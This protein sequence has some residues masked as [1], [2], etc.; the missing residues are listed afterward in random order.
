MWIVG[1]NSDHRTSFRAQISL[2][3]EKSG[4]D[5]GLRQGLAA[6]E[7][8][9]HTLHGFEGSTWTL[10]Q[11]S[12]PERLISEHVFGQLQVPSLARNFIAQVAKLTF[13]ES[14]IDVCLKLA[15]ASNTPLFKI[16]PSANF[17]S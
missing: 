3:S 5:S 11:D 14:C 6:V 8:R 12:G 9:G 1:G 4:R 16:T 17:E 15:W 10:G 7:Q 13:A 2:D